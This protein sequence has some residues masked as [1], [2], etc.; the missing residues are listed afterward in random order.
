M[1][2]REGPSDA[3]CVEKSSN[4]RQNKRKCT[5]IEPTV[6][7]QKQNV[8]IIIPNTHSLNY[9]YDMSCLTVKAV[10]YDNFIGSLSM[11]ELLWWEYN[12]E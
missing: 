8:I 7:S 2:N 12:W 6:S 5:M 10:K 3:N 4:Q 9:E 1:K 11:S